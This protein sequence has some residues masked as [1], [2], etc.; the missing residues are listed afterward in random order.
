MARPRAEQGDP[1]EALSRF[2]RERFEVRALVPE[3]LGDEHAGG[4]S[5]GD[6]PNAPTFLCPEGQA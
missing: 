1:Q 2:M 3:D 6:E 4:A 5:L